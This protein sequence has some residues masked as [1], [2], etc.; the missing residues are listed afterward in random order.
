MRLRLHHAYRLYQMPA[1]YQGEMKR[2]VEE[3]VAAWRIR[4][5]KGPLGASAMFRE[6]K[7]KSGRMFIDYRALNKLTRKGKYTLP[8]IDK[9]LDKLATGKYFTMM[10]FSSSFHKFRIRKGTNRKPPSKLAM[11]LS[12]G[13]SCL[14]DSPMP[15]QL[16]SAPWI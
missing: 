12:S 7:D 15:R 10:D 5:S 6:Q 14:L 11:G 1:A 2:Q 16:F 9:M 8:W 3:L 13:Q 4:P